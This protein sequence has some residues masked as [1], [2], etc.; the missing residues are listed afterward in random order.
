MPTRPV[1][2]I[3]LTLLLGCGAGRTLRPTDEAG[4][5]DPVAPSPVVNPPIAAEPAP[6]PAAD[7]AP[8]PAPAAPS[9]QPDTAANRRTNL[10]LRRIGQWSQSGIGEPR[11]VLIRDESSWEQFWSALNAGPRPQVDFSRNVVIGVAAGERSS[12]GHGIAVERVRLN[13]GELLIEV[14]ET[15]PGPSCVTS[16]AL[17]QPVD[18]VVVAGAG[19]RSWS[20]VERNETRGC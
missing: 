1:A 10:D 11:R 17:T 19:A 6:T 18:V 15:Y 5:A 20:F 7:P 3:A 16:Q 8:A 12:G 14:T 13:D 4:G 2:L 9:G